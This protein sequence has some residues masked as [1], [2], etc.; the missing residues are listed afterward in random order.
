MSGV[1]RALASFVVETPANEIPATVRA[2]AVDTIVDSYATL[3]AGFGEPSS[4]TL[5]AGLLPRSGPGRAVVAGEPGRRV[6]PASAALFNGAAA[7]ALDYDSISFAV[8]G[9][10]GSAT[11][12][13]LAALADE[14][15]CSGAQVL[16]AYV[17]GWEGAAALAR[18]LMPEHYAIG[19]HPTATMSGYAAAL[20]ACRLLGLDTRQTVAAMSV[21]TAETSGIK[22][23]IGNMLNGY[24]VGKAARNGISAAL[25]AQAGFVGHPDPI[26][27]VQGLFALYAGPSGANPE[28]T[29]D[30]LGQSWDLLDPGPVFKIY[31]CC[32]LV[33]SALDAVIALCEEH[34]IAPAEVTSVEVLVHEYVPKVM[35]IARPETGYAAKFC[36]PYCIAAAL[37]DRRVGLAPFDTVDPELTELGNRVIVR[38]HPALNGGA[39]FFEKEFSEVRIATARGRFERRVDRLSNRG[40]GYLDQRALFEKFDE[41]TSRSGGL[42]ADPAGDFDRLQTMETTGIWTLWQK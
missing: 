14:R 35:Q 29:V 18:A 31:A 40:S 11:L 30:T 32:G 21:V 13:A 17:L 36:I 7:H 16:T 33:H 42:V 1:A 5:R 9:F 27:H 6:D 25:L 38:V 37:R 2:R 24:H 3:M 12:Y 34:D 22:I 41:C 19:W 26:E 8:S 28:L 10:V 4:R 23:M 20:G 39:T 15:D